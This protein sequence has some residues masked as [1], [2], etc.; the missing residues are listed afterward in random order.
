MISW[1]ELS[2]G[3]AQIR[4]EEGC[5]WYSYDVAYEGGLAGQWQVGKQVGKWEL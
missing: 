1:L 4:E 3:K 5:R 2:L